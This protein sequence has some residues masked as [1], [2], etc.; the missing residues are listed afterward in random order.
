[1]KSINLSRSAINQIDLSSLDS[2][3]NNAPNYKY[4]NLEAGKEHYKL[5]AYL[6]KIVDGKKVLDIGTYQGLSAAAMSLSGK[7]VD[8]FDIVEDPSALEIIS[9]LDNVHYHLGTEYMHRF[10]EI[11]K[12][13]DLIMLDIDHRGQT[14]KDILK[15]LDDVGY[16]GILMMDDIHLNDAMRDVW[17]SVTRSKYDV[18]T[19]GHWSGTGIVLYGDKYLIA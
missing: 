3:C 10:A 8:T 4:F 13:V 1:M 17:S 9:K 2:I 6:S 16:D 11:I 18:S 19:F 7:E 5:L 15:L 12:D 14:E